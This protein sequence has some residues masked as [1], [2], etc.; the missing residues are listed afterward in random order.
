MAFFITQ[1]TENVLGGK[2]TVTLS[3]DHLGGMA[4]KQPSFQREWAAI[5]HDHVLEA[6]QT[7]RRHR[8]TSEL[9]LNDDETEIVVVL[10]NH[11]RPIYNITKE[12]I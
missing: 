9:Y 7:A 12:E 11:V 4:F 6:L 1:E 10:N 2:L 3:E 8:G 5:S